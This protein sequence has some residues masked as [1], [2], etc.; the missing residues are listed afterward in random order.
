MTFAASL[1][2]ASM[3]VLVG[4]MAW[5][6][7]FWRRRWAMPIRTSVYERRR[8]AASWTPMF[9]LNASLIGINVSALLLSG[10]WISSGISFVVIAVMTCFGWQ[11]RQEQLREAQHLEDEEVARHQVPDHP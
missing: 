2:L 9:V 8:N 6:Y 10:N 3:V 7:V 11:K 4:S 5:L 1:G